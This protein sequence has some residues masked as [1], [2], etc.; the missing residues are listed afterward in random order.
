MIELKHRIGRGVFCA[1]LAASATLTTTQSFAVPRYDG[2][3]SVSIVTTKGD[4]IPSYRYPMLIANGV[5]A[6]GG[7]LPI[8][9]SGKVAPTG[10]IVVMVSNGTTS[11][12]GTGHLSGTSGSGSW[13]GVACAGSWTAQRHDS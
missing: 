7:A 5:L 9:V 1:L 4:C 6:N 8:N 11:A 10:A 3:W 12:T 13:R 2:M